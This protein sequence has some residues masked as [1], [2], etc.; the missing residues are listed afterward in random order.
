MTDSS[1][2]VPFVSILYPGD[3]VTQPNEAP[4]CFSDLNLDQLVSSIVAGREE[5]NL[6]PIFWQHLSDIESIRYRQD[7]LHDL[8]KDDIRACV[9]HFADGMRLYRD[10]AA[11][12]GKLRERYQRG[13]YF[14]DAVG[15]LCESVTR[16]DQELRDLDLESEGMR[17]LR[18][19]LTNYSRSAAF[20]AMASETRSIQHSLADVRYTVHSNGLRVTV[21]R[22][23]GEADYSAEVRDTFRRFEQ[24]GV[25]NYHVEFRNPVELN[26]VEASILELVAELYP[27]EFGTL[28]R[29]F[30]RYQ[31]A[32]DPTLRNFDR[33]VQFFLAF[34][35]FVQRFIEHGLSFCTPRILRGSKQVSVEDSFD[36]AMAGKL[37]LEKQKV[38][39][40]G[41]SLRDPER[42]L[43]VSGP[44]QGGK[45]TFAR[46]FGQIHYLASLGLMVPGK[47]ARLIAFD[48]IFTH[49]EREEDLTDFSG[50]LEDDLVR[51][52]EIFARAT[53]ASIIIMN[54]IF[55]STT[56]EDAEFL[57]TRVLDKI[58]ELGALSVYVSFVDE[59]ASLNDSI[60]SMVSTVN[61]ADPAE[62]TYKVVR[63]PA[64]GLSYAIA[65]A[66]KY[67]LTYASLRGRIRA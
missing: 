41:F 51:A 50:K 62:R 17:A 49:F 46:M 2:G 25:K 35:D 4:S 10:N 3:A 26:R 38:V 47:N 36:V 19:Y 61:P 32:I 21:R 29:Y 27:E 44:N 59:L 58:T 42:I 13:R 28:E 67:K 1:H 12:A 34:Q 24:G 40:N 66:E 52:R 8:E 63:Q 5:Y 23:S 43:V 55:T 64:D 60:V 30:A 65:I 9:D 15:Y 33:D 18:V 6:T 20:Q 22:Y 31:N 57:G 7:V 48:D 11:L 16:F 14:L 54:E 39:T 37:L 56:L 53:S 45:T